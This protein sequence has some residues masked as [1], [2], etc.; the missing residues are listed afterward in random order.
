MRG[1]ADAARGWNEREIAAGVAPEHRSFWI[2]PEFG[3]SSPALLLHGAGGSPADLRLLAVDLARSGI[4]SLAP[5]L[6]A[7][8]LGE[9]A[10]GAI[11][12]DALTTRSIEAFDLVARGA[13][14]G[15]PPPFLF[16]L[17]M[18]GV[19]GIHV[20]TRRPVRAFVA[21]APALR[22]FVLRRAFALVP[23]V[24][25]AP[26]LALLRYRWQQEVWRGIRATELEIPRVTAPLLV[27]HSRDDASVSIA[28]SR[29]LHD[30]AASTRKHF[31]CVDGQG[32]VLTT[33]PNPDVVF[34]PVR[35]FLRV[36]TDR[37]GASVVSSPEDRM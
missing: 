2:E 19:L 10:L 22:P 32:H 25:A 6:P 5:L 34:G 1:P 18:G 35:E 27:M 17:S 24:L 16:G 8:G 9:N 13:G 15:G 14:A 12:F 11:R 20:A 4:A 28:G 23:Q 21:F 30:G 7:H 36:E 29:L 31:A 37:P 3:D 26:R 33:P